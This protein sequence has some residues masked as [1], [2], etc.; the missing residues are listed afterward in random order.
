[1]SGVSSVNRGQSTACRVRVAW[2]AEG[3]GRARRRTGVALILLATSVLLGLAAPAQKKS[4]AAP[5]SRARAVQI[6]TS[7]CQ[8]CHGPEGVAPPTTPQL[9]FVGR[10]WKHGSGPAQIEATIA[11]GV[12][13][14]AMLP[15]KAR[16]TRAEIAALARL[17]L[18]YS[19][20]PARDKAGREP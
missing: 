17:V 6:Y 3:S 13:G 8:Q 11:N 20:K 16:L 10:Q 1:M 18:S 7:T 14:T 15:F 5:V 9:S 12:P 19:R 2:G 4:A